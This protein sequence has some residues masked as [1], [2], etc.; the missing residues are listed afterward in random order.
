MGIDLIVQ[1]KELCMVNGLN[2]K[3]VKKKLANEMTGS[4]M[5]EILV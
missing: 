2:I 3:A 1:K 5:V 4:F